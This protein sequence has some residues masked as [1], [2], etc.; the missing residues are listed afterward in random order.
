LWYFDKTSSQTPRDSYLTWLGQSNKVNTLAIFDEHRGP[1][2][3][4]YVLGFD[5]VCRKLVRA[6][7]SNTSRA[8]QS[9]VPH[10]LIDRFPRPGRRLWHRRVLSA[11]AMAPSSPLP[12]VGAPVH[13]SG[14]LSD[15]ESDGEVPPKDI[16]TP[17]KRK[18]PTVLGTPAVP[19]RYPNLE[20]P[21]QVGRFMRKLIVH[22][23]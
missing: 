20:T 5:K 23:S 8:S 15:T 1:A 21:T 9:L 10:N 19:S 7:S 12:P 2:T 18:K 17:T 16:T 3:T 22:L 4:D 6:C 13:S 11:E 14:K